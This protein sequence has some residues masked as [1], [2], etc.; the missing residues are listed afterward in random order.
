M[1]VSNA[2]IFTL[3]S[4]EGCCS[5]NSYDV[6]GDKI[7]DCEDLDN[8]DAHDLSR[9]LNVEATEM[10]VSNHGYESDEDYAPDQPLIC[11]ICYATFKTKSG[12][13]N[14]KVTH[15]KFRTKEFA[16]YICY[17]MFYWDKDCRR[18]IKNI[19]GVENYNREESRKAARLNQKTNRIVHHQ[20][21]F[22][23]QDKHHLI[24]QYQQQERIQPSQKDP[25]HLNTGQMSSRNNNIFKM[26]IELLK[27]HEKITNTNSSNETPSEYKMLS[28]EIPSN[29]NDC[30]YKDDNH[31]SIDVINDSKDIQY[32]SDDSNDE[33]TNSNKYLVKENS[34]TQEEI[35]NHTQKVKDDLGEL[36]DDGGSSEESFIGNED[37][38]ETVDPDQYADENA[39]KYVFDSFN[40]ND[41]FS[42]VC[43]YVDGMSSNTHK[44]FS[45]ENIEVNDNLTVDMFN[46][47]IPKDIIIEP[48]SDS[49]LFLTKRTYKC[50]HCPRKF[51]NVEYLKIHE[52]SCL[53]L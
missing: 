47:V 23:N 22:Q 17:R 27:S 48:K 3:Y 37:A 13:R 11:K 40:C 41:G 28:K 10:E 46:F 42:S 31:D 20:P 2:H 45:D 4:C 16:C 50:S 29:V 43:S 36:L 5:V 25:Q 9:F 14:H 49:D 15:Q 33:L 38:F 39:S 53:F 1:V 8:E 12:W 32:R 52:K 6:R 51:V 44:N 30:F 24:Q 35:E 34:I 21:S 26:K 7:A 18:H 19:H